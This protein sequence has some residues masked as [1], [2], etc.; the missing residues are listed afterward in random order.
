MFIVPFLQDF[1]LCEDFLPKILKGNNLNKISYSC[2][3]QEVIQPALAEFYLFSEN[4]NSRNKM[5]S[6]IAELRQPKRTNY[7]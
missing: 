5:A 6:R 1:Y 2:A 3:K 4:R 7:F